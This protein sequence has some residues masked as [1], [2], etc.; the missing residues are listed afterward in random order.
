KEPEESRRTIE[1]DGWVH[2]GDL[3]MQDEDEY[4]Y[5]VGTPITIVLFSRLI[6]LIVSS[7][8]KSP[9][10]IVFAPR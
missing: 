3:V 5:I 7:G 2:T 9:I 1:Q 4:Y 6:T 10:N 8:S